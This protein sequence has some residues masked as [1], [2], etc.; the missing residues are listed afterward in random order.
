VTG[1]PP[2]EEACLIEAGLDFA[3]SP[4]STLGVSY[5]GQIASDVSDN[6][7]EGRFSWLF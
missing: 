1:V 5:S 2:S 7:V 6:A 4:S 3:L